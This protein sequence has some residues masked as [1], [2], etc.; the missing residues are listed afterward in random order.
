MIETTRLSPGIKILIENINDM[1]ALTF[2]SSIGAIQGAVILLSILFRFRHRKNLPLALLLIVFSLRLGTIPTWTPGIL[3]SYPW[4]YPL[5]AP[6]P[7]LFGPLLWFSI[8]QF[9]SDTPDFPRHITLHLL[10]YILEVAAILYTLL[11]MNSREYA[12][13]IQSVFSGNPPLW[14]PLRNGMKVLL[15]LVYLLVSM[16]IVFSSKT[17]R[18]SFPKRLRLRSLVVIPLIVLLSFSYVAVNPSATTQLTRGGATP[19]IV[20]SMTMVVLIYTISFFLMV[21]PGLFSW[22][23]RS[24]N[25]QRERLCSE[26]ECRYL[27][28]L[29]EKRLSEGAFKNP[30]LVISDFAAEFK[31]HPNR[32]SHAVNRCF[33]SSFR[34]LLNSR[35]L[36]YFSAR[37]E[38]GAHNEQSL[39]ETAFE[40]GFPSKSTFNRVFKEKRGISPTQFI[41]EKDKK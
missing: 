12:H 10:P 28:G 27:A 39:L 17:D 22:E 37:I 5:T 15:N 21:T 23:K 11:S 25:I 36:D 34:E 7:F 29:V 6:L 35:R 4:I 40:A 14:L 32:L 2:I 3:L 30:D 31:V 26:E 19:F 8:R 20:L 1:H 41:R 13:F 38:A 9:V 18:L 33:N 16:G 24:P